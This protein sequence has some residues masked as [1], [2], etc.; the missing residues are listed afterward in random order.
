MK[1]KLKVLDKKGLERTVTRLAHEILDRNKGG[2]T[3]ALVGMQTRGVYIARRIA[4]KIEGIEGDTPLLGTLDVTLFRDDFRTRLKQPQ[5]K[6]TDIPFSLDEKDVILIDDV[7][8]T[9]RT[10]RGALDALMAFGRPA[11]IQYVALVDRG[12]RELPIEANFIG[13]K[14]PTSIDEEVRVKV[15]EVDGEDAVLLVDMSGSEEN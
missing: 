14:V 13:K 6:V 10:V 7:L 3:I 2:G 9:G 4:K 5:V 8:F 1:V 12:H 15:K 11:S